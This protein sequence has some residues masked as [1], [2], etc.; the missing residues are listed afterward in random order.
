[1]MFCLVGMCQIMSTSFQGRTRHVAPHRL[2]LRQPRLQRIAQPHE[3]V[4]L[5]DDALLFRGGVD[6]Y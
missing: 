5:C 1:M 4:N 2:R 3:L 6:R